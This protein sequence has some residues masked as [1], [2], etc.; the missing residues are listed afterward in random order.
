MPRIRQ[1]SEAY[2]RKDFQKAIGRAQVDA[3]LTQKKLL[4][5]AAGIPYATLWRRM[6]NPEDLSLKQMRQLL[7]VLP[8][9]AEALLAFLEEDGPVAVL[10]GSSMSEKQIIDLLIVDISVADVIVECPPYE[11]DVGD[12]VEFTYDDREVVG[13]VVRKIISWK[14]SEEYSFLSTVITIYKA[15]NI[16]RK[17][18]SAADAEN[19]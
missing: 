4:A 9:P 19:Q 17:G 10:P 16:W 15:E 14:D 11:A 6:E 2:A 3:D 7:S 12:L 13:T 1:N 8:I 18:W 5:E